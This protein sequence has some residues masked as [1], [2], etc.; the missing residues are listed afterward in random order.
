MANKAYKLR[1]RKCAYFRNTIYFFH[2][3]AIG[4]YVDVRQ[5]N[6]YDEIATICKI[7]TLAF[8]AH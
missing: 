1:G 8:A 7:Y 3:A 5:I 4:V 6:P 2:Y